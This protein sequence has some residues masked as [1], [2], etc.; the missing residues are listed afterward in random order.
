MKKFALYGSCVTRDVFNFLDNEIYNPVVTVE[1]NPIRTLFG[2]K[3][4]IPSS[5]ID[6]DT[7]FTNRMI[8][9][10]FSKEVIDIL[11]SV[12]SE[13][14][15]FDMTSERMPLQTW[16][17]EGEATTVPVNWGT[18]CLGKELKNTQKYESLSISNW[19]MA[20]IEREWQEEIQKFCQII[21]KKYDSSK[22]ILLSL[23]QVDS[24]LDRETFCT[25]SLTI[26][27][28]EFTVG[29]DKREL[30]EKQNRIIRQAE[31][32]VLDNIPNCWVIKMPNNVIGNATHHFKE[33]PLHFHYLY[34]EYAAD[35]I[36]LIAK[37]RKE[38]NRE[39]IQKQLNFLLKR[40]TEKFTR[41]N[42]FVERAGCKKIQYYG[43]YELLEALRE[44][45]TFYL[46]NPVY[47]VAMEAILAEPLNITRKE[48]EG[49]LTDEEQVKFLDDANKICRLSLEYSDAEWLVVDFR[50]EL[51]GV[52]NFDNKKVIMDTYYEKLCT[53]LKG[54]N[55]RLRS[56][57][58]SEQQLV[59]NF[60]ELLLK[61]WNPE[62]II[63]IENY[64]NEKYV[65]HKL[66]LKKNVKSIEMNQQL[67]KIYKMMYKKIANCKVIYKPKNSISFCDDEKYITMDEKMYLKSAV[68]AMV[69]GEE[70][71]ISQLYRELE[72]KNEIVKRELK[73]KM[74]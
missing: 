35:A 25:K 44:N 19:R 65:N 6:I 64:Y 37:E 55:I 16:S 59:D 68:H 53:I 32:Y 15:I 36:K 52:V 4:N 5:D 40:Y 18:Y 62:K 48:L 49:K 43:C 3:L 39:V 42:Q 20:D 22:I 41:M 13:Y 61:K 70:V 67:R 29:I 50:S 34:Y 28:N 74:F 45:D 7:K 9:Y 71:V 72:V 2:K 11:K 21:L 33:H 12:E 60:C 69:N 8:S 14:F 30:R 58:N 26:N 23:Q 47:N 66:Q 38:K 10:N 46:K 17:Y 63:V 24:I 73:R 31:K 54:S 27:R 1:F 57:D 51:Y 56:C